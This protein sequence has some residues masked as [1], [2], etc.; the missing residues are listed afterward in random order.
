[1]DHLPWNFVEAELN[2]QWM[3]EI[4]PQLLP[5]H[6]SVIIRLVQ[7]SY[8]LVHWCIDAVCWYCDFILRKTIPWNNSLVIYNY[9]IH[10]LRWSFL[11][12]RL[13]P[14]NIGNKSFHKQSLSHSEL[15]CETME[16]RYLIISLLLLKF[17]WVIS[18]I[19][20]EPPLRVRVLCM[21]IIMS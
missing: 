10:H 5:V 12:C 21:L 11:K 1:M 3:A 20:Q 9:Y 16:F 15:W 17:L 6:T 13:G 18:Y 2:V 19:L 4:S 8:Q 14:S 7:N